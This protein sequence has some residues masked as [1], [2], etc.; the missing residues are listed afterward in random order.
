MGVTFVGGGLAGAIL[1]NIVSSFRSRIQPVGKKISV[2][3]LFSP[4]ITGS[5]LST[6]V[7]ISDDIS[8]YQFSNL[9]VADI[10]IANRGNQDISKFLL[11]VTLADGDKCVH[12]E[13]TVKDRHH[14]VIPVT[15]VTPA[16]PSSTIDFT[17]N[18][19]NRG[20]EYNLRIFIV[21]ADCEPGS[22]SISSPEPIRFVEIPTI[23]ET[24]SDIAVKV[25]P[26]VIRSLG[27]RY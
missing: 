20:N 8:S 7:T 1:N 23:S 11:G 14:A 5:T 12:I 13:S 6:T 15:Q 27:T 26:V 2:S 25:G 19:F 10:C 16:N 17:L 21:A 4:G 9:H 22:I 18:P 24:L 3:P